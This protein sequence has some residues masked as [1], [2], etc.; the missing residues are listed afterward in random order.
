MSSTRSHSRA[1]SSTD[2]D[3]APFIWC[4]VRRFGLIHEGF[5]V[6][7]RIQ[8]VVY[9][10]RLHTVDGGYSVVNIRYGKNSSNMDARSLLRNKGFVM[11]PTRKAPPFLSHDELAEEW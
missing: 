1:P 3:L 7:C 5:V 4:N 10:Q 2:D 8:N 11:H 6:V 9:R